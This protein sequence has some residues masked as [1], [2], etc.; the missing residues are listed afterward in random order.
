MN[1][2]L[3]TVEGIQKPLQLIRSKNARYMRISINAAAEVKVTIPWHTPA[4]YVYD[5]LHTKKEWILQTL[6]KIAQNPGAA[7]LPQLFTEQTEF[8][9]RFHRLQIIAHPTPQATIKIGNGLILVKY[10]HTLPI[11]NPKLQDFIKKGI[12]EALR[13]EAKLYLP[14]RLNELAILHRFVYNGVF[15]KNLKSKWGSC[16]HQNNI[17]LNLHLMRLPEKL[18]DYVLVHELVH[19]VVKNHSADFWNLLQAKMPDAKA[20]HLEMK[21]YNTNL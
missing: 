13:M 2:Q 14:Q 17:N 15:I 9:T 5:M 3:L 12:T 4:E 10:P 19:T 21:K 16:S 1:K 18:I 6:S 20:R 7:A 8:N 11:S